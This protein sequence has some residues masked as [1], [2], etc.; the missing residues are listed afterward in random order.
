[1]R[2]ILDAL[3]WV[4]VVFAVATAVYFASAKTDVSAGVAD[5]KHQSEA[6]RDACR[7]CRFDNGI[8]DTDDTQ[9]SDQTVRAF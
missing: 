7:T 1:M 8:E 5:H 4:F 2:R 3:T 6:Q 9:T